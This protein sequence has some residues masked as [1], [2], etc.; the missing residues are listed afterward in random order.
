MDTVNETDRR[1]HKKLVVRHQAI[2]VGIKLEV[3][4]QLLLGEPVIIVFWWHRHKL[5]SKIALSV[6]V[7]VNRSKRRHLEAFFVLLRQF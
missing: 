2:A 6:V 7:Q 3:E 5:Q 1:P 4:Q